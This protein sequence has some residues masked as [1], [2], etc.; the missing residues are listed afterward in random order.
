M[1]AKELGLSYNIFLNYF[2]FELMEIGTFFTNNPKVFTIR[3]CAENYIV[4]QKSML[5]LNICI[6]FR[7]NYLMKHVKHSTVARITNF[8]RQTLNAKR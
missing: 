8:S 4:S 7:L 3:L 1:S 6:C 5:F 2:C